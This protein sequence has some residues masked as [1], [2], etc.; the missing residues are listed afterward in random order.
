MAERTPNVVTSEN[1]STFHAKALDIAPKEPPVEVKTEP[2]PAAQAEK[3]EP[4]AAKPEVPETHEE[5]PEEKRKRDNRERWEKL[6]KDRRAAIEKVERLEHENA[7]LQAKLHPLAQVPEEE[8]DPT[9]YTEITKYRDDL[10]KWE[11]AQVLKEQQA[12]EARLDAARLDTEWTERVKHAAQAIPDFQSVLSGSNI[13]VP[14]WV[15]DAIKTSEVGPNILYHLAKNPDEAEKINKMTPVAAVRYIGKLETTL[16]NKSS[17]ELETK[18]ENL[19]QVSNAP[20]PITPVRSAVTNEVPGRNP[21]GTW[22]SL[23]DY[24]AARAKGYKG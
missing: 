8:P 12:E 16:E 5:T 17:P 13:A 4:E 21:D 7:E 10:K 11:R 24:K 14:D 15:R 9:Q 23:A 20:A 19:V 3:K 18:T 22:K 2:A 6:T 1:L